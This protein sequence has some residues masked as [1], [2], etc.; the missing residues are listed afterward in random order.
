MS[1]TSDNVHPFLHASRSN[2]VKYLLGRQILGKEV[3]DIHEIRV[4]QCFAP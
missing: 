3:L 1:D 2:L 4:G